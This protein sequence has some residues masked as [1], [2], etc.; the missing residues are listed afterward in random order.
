MSN[1][2]EEWFS[3]QKISSLMIPASLLNTCYIT[4]HQLGWAQSIRCCSH[5]HWTRERSLQGVL[6]VWF[7]R[8]LCDHWECWTLEPCTN[9]LGE[10]NKMW[11]ACHVLKD[12]LSWIHGTQ[13]TRIVTK[14]GTRV[15]NWVSQHYGELS[16]LKEC[17]KDQSLIKYAYCQ[18]YTTSNQWSHRTSE[19]TWVH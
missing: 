7:A 14:N 4:S 13:L 2:L 9:N 3:C 19:D 18:K 5:L 12:S 15:E 1:A 16:C 17:W 11:I 6:V 8:E 10:T